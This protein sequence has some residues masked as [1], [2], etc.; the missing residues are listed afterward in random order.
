[1][2]LDISMKIDMSK[3]ACPYLN[4]RVSIVTVRYCLTC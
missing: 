4:A 1:M 2:K 3:L